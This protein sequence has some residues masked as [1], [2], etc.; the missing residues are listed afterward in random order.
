MT[1]LKQL[2]HNVVIHKH[3]VLHRHAV[4]VL[5]VPRQTLQ[6]PG[7]LLD[8]LQLD[9]LNRVRLQHPIDQVAHLLT[10]EVVQEV[11]ALLNLLKEH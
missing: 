8:L 9:S 10:S 2:A 7:V 1:Y 4:E 6:V 11:L 3:L 5:Q